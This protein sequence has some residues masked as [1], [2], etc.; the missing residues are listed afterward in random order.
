MHKKTQYVLSIS[1]HSPETNHT[2]GC[3][4]VSK[5]REIIPP[6]NS[7][8]LRPPCRMVSSSGAQHVDLHKWTM[9]L[10]IQGGPQKWSGG[11][12]TSP[13]RTELGLFNVW[14]EEKALGKPF[15]SLP[16]SGSGLQQKQRDFTQ[17]H[18]VI[19][20]EDSKMGKG[21]SSLDGRAGICRGSLEK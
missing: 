19:G 2:M 17:I 18:V 15:S 13:V 5:P 14:R 11:W 20:I 21:V 3:S 1:T 6:Q 8:L 4:K 9:D 7:P 10:L 16:A 12:S